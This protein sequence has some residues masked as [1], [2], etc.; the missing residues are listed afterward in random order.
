[1]RILFHKPSWHPL[2]GLGGLRGLFPGAQP[3][4]FDPSGFP[5]SAPKAW[6][7]VLWSWMT[8][9]SEFFACILFLFFIFLSLVTWGLGRSWALESLR[10]ALVYGAVWFAWMAYIVY[11]LPASFR[12]MQFIREFG[13]WV[14][15][16][17]SYS[18]VR[19]LIPAV[20]PTQLDQALRA[21]EVRLWGQEAAFWTQTLFG[22]PYWT[23]FFCLLYLSLFLWMFA[24]LFYYALTR[25]PLYQRFMLG[26][27]LIYIGGFIGYLFCPAAG[28]RY[29]FPQEWTWLNGGTLFQ[30]TNLI[31]SNMGA[32]LDVF[33][34]LHAALSI[35]LLFWQSQYR[36]AQVLWGLPL[37]LGIWV[38]TIFLGFH[39]FP[40][41]VGGGFLGG[42]ALFLAPWL[43]ARFN[44]VKNSLKG[45]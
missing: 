2:K 11:F 37:A 10:Y 42:L 36:K 3:K 12:P 21:M 39:Y 17:L 29:A 45:P 15:V 24:F 16:M 20:H 30:L 23:D 14:A 38:S 44:R 26:L 1:M 25:H 43:E 33:P 27:M 40:D 31:V 32:K 4:S 6:Q 13:P 8:H 35:Y 22:H 19:Y 7:K 34:S 5:L 9:P 41:L 18:W 28:P